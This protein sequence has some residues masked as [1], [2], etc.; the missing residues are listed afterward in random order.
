MKK[1]KILHCADIHFDT[2]FKELGK[3]LSEVSKEEL[4]EVFKKI[5]NIVIDEQVD[6]LLIAGDVFDN[7]TV[8]KTTLYFIA[9]QL[10]RINNT[11]VFIS[12]G[13]HDPYNSRSFY[14]IMDW[15]ENVYIFKGELEKVDLEDLNLTVWGA[16]FNNQYEKKT[17]FRNVEIDNS[18]INLMVI[19]G[20]ISNNIS[21]NIYNPIYLEDIKK[22]GMEYIAV[23]HRHEFSGIKREGK[24]FYAY[25]GCPQGRGFD[26]I[27]DKGI[28]IGD[29]AKDEVHLSF[30]PICKRK[31]NTVEIDISGLDTYEEVC[32]VI[33]NSFPKDEREN[34]LFKI[35]LKGQLKEHLIINEDVLLSKLK[36]QFYYLKIINNTSV[37]INMD[38]LA[39]EFSV[40]GRFVSKML[41]ILA[42]YPEEDKE[43]INLAI[44][45]GIQSLSESEVKLDDN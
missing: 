16:A 35:V 20:E 31:Y 42:D 29:I 27:G 28:I 14:E 44:K 33:L 45:L 15:P 22:S 12:P 6:I 18:R 2:P 34:N 23:G 17:L 37:E 41:K 25:S 43:I 4:L 38:E 36:D 21:E 3:K 13:N 26:E 19:H 24:T 8:N 7:F 32:S 5:I 40:K 10:S 30:R 9:S 39:S 1:I 11:Q